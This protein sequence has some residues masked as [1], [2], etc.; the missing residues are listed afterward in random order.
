MEGKLEGKVAIVTGA[1]QG[2]GEAV[3]K[4]F[5]QEGA[6][7]V[8]NDIIEEKAKKVAEEINSQGKEALAIRADVTNHRE[9]SR[10]VEETVKEF[11]TVHILINNAGILRS[12]TKEVFPFP[13]WELRKRWRALSFF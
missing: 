9:V 3:A 8:V 5:A 1:A 4:L 10:M 11:G 6:K 2:M 13:A 7:V 12:T